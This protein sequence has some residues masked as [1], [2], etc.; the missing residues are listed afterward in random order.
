MCPY[1]L[2]PCFLFH[3]PKGD[4]MAA[5]QS[6]TDVLNLAFEAKAK[7]EETKVEVDSATAATQA[8][9]ADAAAKTAA[10]QAIE[11]DKQA[12]YDNAAADLAAKKEQALVVL[13]AFLSP[14]ATAAMRLA[15]KAR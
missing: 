3:K 6:V 15:L 11:A 1:F 5:P 2:C 8:V 9:I 7:V 14:G 4:Q 13:A 10:A 12:T